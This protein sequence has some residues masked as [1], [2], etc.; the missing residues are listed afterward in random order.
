MKSY[1]KPIL[2]FIAAASASIVISSAQTMDLQEC[3]SQTL[4]H[5]YSN[6]IVRGNLEK[7]ENDVTIS[8][9]MP[10]VSASAG[11]TQSQIASSYNAFSA[12]AALGW[13]LFDGLAMFNIHDRNKVM[14]NQ[15][16]LNLISNIE[17]LVYDVADR[18]YSII[19][20][21]SRRETA[22]QSLAISEQRYSEALAKY[23][24]GVLSGLEMTMAKIDYNADSSRLV[25]QTEALKVAYITLNKVMNTDLSR[26]G[27]INDTI[28]LQPKLDYSLLHRLIME[29]NVQ[30][31]LSRLGQRISALDLNLARAARSPF[32]DFNAGYAYN[33][34][35]NRT[36][37]GFNLGLSAG[38]TLF[39][40]LETNRK[41]KNAKV[42]IRN[43][44]LSYLETENEILANFA[45]Q[46]E[47]YLSNLVLIGFETENAAAAKLNVE[48]ALERFRLGSLSGVEFRE[49]QRSYLDAI[50][51]KL[52]AIY[53][54]K[55]SEI[56]ILRLANEIAN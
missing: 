4:E 8:P 53:Q 48:I 30:L 18:Y 32:I 12:G 21:Q 40:G 56:S 14:R 33:V 54:A 47:V 27:Y 9:F 7:A 41:I 35:G 3:I 55:A 50:D 17:N 25:T 29:Q 23:Q 15:A 31:Q 44:E 5:N 10:I 13:R 45:E 38:V 2:T 46:Y 34:A 51:R 26:T 1:L 20:L 42:D 36:R 11:Q 16:E 19:T 22:K 6:K 28:V 43:S 39:N 52:V 49:I 37:A 24:L